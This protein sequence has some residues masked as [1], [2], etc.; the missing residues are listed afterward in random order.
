MLPSA[1]RAEISRQYFDNSYLSRK[2]F[3]V[4]TSGR[5]REGVLDEEHQSLHDRYSQQHSPSG[6]Q[7]PQMPQH[8][9]S[10]GK[11]PRSLGK[12]GSSN[13]HT[14]AGLTAFDEDFDHS[15]DY[16]MRPSAQ[17]Q[18]RGVGRAG[19]AEDLHSSFRYTG[20]FDEDQITEDDS[21]YGDQDSLGSVRSGDSYPSIKSAGGIRY[22]NSTAGQ[23]WTIIDR[24]DDIILEVKV[25][26]PWTLSVDVLSCSRF[27]LETQRK[28]NREFCCSVQGRLLM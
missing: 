5:G 24:L 16:G 17:F 7:M 10:G 20:G 19:G 23:I 26:L 11:Q 27:L 2:A 3:E 25:R 21:A 14:T 28:L 13:S 9:R 4:D 12:H 1:R 18:G 22:S 15:D 8:G 6:P